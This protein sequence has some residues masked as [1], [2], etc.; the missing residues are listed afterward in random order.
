MTQRGSW[1]FGSTIVYLIWHL[2]TSCSGL[3]WA[4]LL[5]SFS[6]MFGKGRKHRVSNK[7]AHMGGRPALVSLGVGGTFLGV[8]TGWT[9]TQCKKTQKDIYYLSELKIVSDFFRKFRKSRGRKKECYI[10]NMFF[11]SLMLRGHREALISRSQ[12]KLSQLFSLM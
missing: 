3:T 8:E 7:E 5:M 4:S 11:F 12:I 2:S 1:Q 10:A 9:G 6:R